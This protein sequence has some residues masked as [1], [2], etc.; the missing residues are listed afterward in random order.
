MPK[1]TSKATIGDIIVFTADERN[2]AMGSMT[3]ETVRANQEYVLTIHLD[4][5]I[6]SR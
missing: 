3:Y 4:G 6:P 2:N 1:V 5:R